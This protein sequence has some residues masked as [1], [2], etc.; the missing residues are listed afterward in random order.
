MERARR[1]ETGLGGETY[2]WSIFKRWVE[3]GSLRLVS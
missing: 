1:N 2:S 3:K